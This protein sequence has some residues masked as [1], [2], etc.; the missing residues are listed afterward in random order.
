M[1]KL[2][3]NGF[4]RIG[5]LVFRNIFLSYPNIEIGAVNT[6]GSMDIEGLAHLLRYDTVY[7]RFGKE[8]KVEHANNPEELGSLIIDNKRIPFLGIREPEKIPWAKYGISTVIEA[9]GI[10]KDQE[11]AGKHLSAGAKKVV[12]S[13][14]PKDATPIYIMGVNQHDYKGQTIVSN[15]SCTT[16]CAAP[17]IKIIN[18]FF[19][20]EKV[21]MTTIHAYTSTQNIV[22]GSH[23]D[24][25]RARAAAS[26]IIPTSTGAAKAVVASLP[27]LSGKFMA[28][29]IRVPTLTGS[30]S[31]FTFFL[32]K[33][34]TKEEVNNLFIRKSMEEFK[35]LVFATTDE[36]VS[37]DIIGTT[38]SAIVDLSLTE[39]L[40]G[41][42]VK[43]YAWYDNEWAYTCRLIELASFISS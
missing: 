7:G 27:I 34:T 8:V 12:I 39:V 35:S 3:I 4:G 40:G 32:P 9:T 16:N 23:K 14:P 33:Q 20:L 5:K 26:N 31:D 22:D 41:N 28:S 17:V 18:D 11:K 36:I 15:G 30:L 37:S 24:L 13:A 29:A 19:G 25:R 1:I 43:V 2:S 21:A 42:L 6:S 38:F 10:F